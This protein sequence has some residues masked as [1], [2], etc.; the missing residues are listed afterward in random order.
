MDLRRKGMK[1]DGTDFFK[2]D[3][4]NIRISKPINED[5]SD[6]SSSENDLLEGGAVENV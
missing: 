6:E 4:Q 5:E 3:N 2:D 1:I